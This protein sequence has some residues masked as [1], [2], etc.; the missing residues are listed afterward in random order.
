[1]TRP[2]WWRSLAEHGE[3]PDYLAAASGEFPPAEKFEGVDRRRFLQ[4]LAASAALGGLGGCH[5]SQPPEHIV[6]RVDAV[7]GEE[8]GV[9]RQVA[10]ALVQQ[11]YATG[12]ILQHR[13][14]RPVKL[15]G[16]PDHPASLGAADATMQA[17]VLDLYDPERSTAV[18]SGG[19]IVDWNRL[20]LLMAEKRGQWS[21]NGGAGLRL[22]TGRVASP[23]L[24][25]QIAAL[26]KQ[27]PAAGWHQWE[28]LS[29]DAVAAGA[30]LA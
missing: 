3:D 24:A 4:L 23:T 27:Y 12:A 9:P 15:E 13:M 1:M 21:K 6:P 28:P 5:E 16:N 8:A 17:A 18:L 19:Q 25:A 10:T 14:G 22:L 7:G 11:G 2:Y 30:T 26:L 20:A 29:R